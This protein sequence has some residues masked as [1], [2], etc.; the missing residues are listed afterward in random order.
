MMQSL[1]ERLLI[2]KLGKHQKLGM[3]HCISV[4]SAVTQMDLQTRIDKK[5]CTQGWYQDFSGTTASRLQ[6]RTKHCSEN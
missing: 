1:Y 6:S 5:F 2:P 4:F 3:R